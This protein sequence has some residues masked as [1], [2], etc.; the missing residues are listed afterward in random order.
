MTIRSLQCTGWMTNRIWMRRWD[1]VPSCCAFWNKIYTTFKR[2]LTCIYL[3]WSYS[4]LTSSAI[5]TNSSLLQIL[6]FSAWGP[7]LCLHHGFAVFSVHQIE[8]HVAHS[9]LSQWCLL[10]FIVFPSLSH[11]H[12]QRGQKPTRVS[13]IFMH[14][15]DHN[16]VFLVPYM[17]RCKLEWNPIAAVELGSPLQPHLCLLQLSVLQMYS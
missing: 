14:S 1:C 10:A 9:H 4:N 6:V 7:V 5:C 2:Y 17:L 3:S 11:L 8:A 12:A 15:T 16:Q 13:E